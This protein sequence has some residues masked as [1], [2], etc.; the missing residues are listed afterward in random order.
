MVEKPNPDQRPESDYRR[1]TVKRGGLRTGYTTG[2]CA[3][4]AAKTATRSL[5]TGES[6]GQSTI[7][8]PVGK[9]VTFEIHRC[10]T[11]DDGSKVTCSVIKDGGDDPDVTHGAE[12]CATVYRDP[13][14]AD[15][16]RI[17]GGIGVGTVTRPGVG[18]EV[19]EPAVTRVPRR[20][21]IDSVNES[22]TAYGL[23]SEPGLVVEIYVPHGH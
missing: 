2:A 19:G 20:M 18:I 15:K 6:V 11:S 16:V 9:S 8:L 22:A 21:I 17:T 3:A 4:A 5:L 23:P 13:N 12:I 7:Q 1:Q 14:F 10:Q